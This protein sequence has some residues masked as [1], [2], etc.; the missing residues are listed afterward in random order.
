M[1]INGLLGQTGQCQSRKGGGDWMKEVKEL[2]KEH[3][4]CIPHVRRQ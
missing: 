2:A 4:M 3:M 1:I